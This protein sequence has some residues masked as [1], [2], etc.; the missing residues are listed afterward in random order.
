MND[1]AE[2]PDELILTASDALARCLREDYALNQQRAGRAVW[3]TPRIASLRQWTA[4]TWADTWPVEQLISGTQALALWLEVIECDERKLLSSLACAREALRAERLALSYGIDPL[5]LPAYSEE[6]QAWQRWRRIVRAR[7]HR[8][9][10]LLREDLDSVALVGLRNGRWPLHARIKL[11]GFDL[12]QPPATQ[13]LLAAL[14]TRSTVENTSLAPGTAKMKR[15]LCPDADQQFRHIAALIRRQL[16]AGTASIPPRIVVALA[17]TEARREALDEALTDLVAPW[18]R[19][20]GNS[21]GTPWRWERGQALTAQAWVEAASAVFALDLENNPVDTISRLLLSPVLWQDLI[22][23][24]ASLDADLRRLGRP[25]LRLET[26]LELAPTSLRAAL[27]ALIAALRN[28]PRRARPSAWAEHLSTRLEALSWPGTAV[29]PS[30]VFQSVRE[31][32]QRLSRLG[33]MDGMLGPV[34]IGRA[35]LWLGELL[36]NGFEPRVEHEQPITIGTPEEVLALPCDLLI[37]GD[38]NADIFPG[39]SA[40]TPFLAIE[41][42]R[43]AG[44]PEASPEAHLAHSRS[45]IA[46]LCGQATEVQILAPAVDTRGAELLPSP[47]FGDDWQVLPARKCSSQCNSVAERLAAA[48]PTLFL[49][50]NDP[51][52]P[53]TATENISGNAGLFTAWFES[54]FFAFCTHRLGLEPLPQPGHGLDPRIQGQILHTALERL[55][56]TLHNSTALAALDADALSTEVRSALRAP[57]ARHLPERDFGRVMTQLESARL[58]DLLCQ[59]LR[60][61]LRRSDP[62]EVIACEEPLTTSLAGLPLS[63]RIDRLDHVDTACGPRYL[64]LDYKTGREADPKG[65]REDRLRDPQLPLYA[66][67]SAQVQLLVPQIDGIG[68]AHLKDG[69]PALSSA[70]NWCGSMIEPD[71]QPKRDWNEQLSA[72]SQRLEAAARGFLAGEAGVDPALRSQSWYGWLLPLTG[73]D[74]DPDEAA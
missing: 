6:Q 16:Q 27:T 23:Q 50:E 40:P 55:W 58:H 11:H 51:V 36:R 62:F 20:A 5:R 61:E 7:M 70:N 15:F 39:R 12:Q 25:R 66:T 56:K 33:A 17:D 31:L 22:Q 54:P 3:R 29:L 74:A 49:P 43:A 52:P 30:P 32:R 10:W 46:A 53:V 63:L 42:Q 9:H 65:W 47:L 38:A 28:E 60:H 41:A 2:L 18:R 48:P 1:A 64:V 19:R 14:R 24:T 13:A 4:D 8:N 59:W 72:W 21:H 37:I 69:H 71:T 34:D 44:I 45:L 68:F 67:L 73:T 26:L 57:L 35:R